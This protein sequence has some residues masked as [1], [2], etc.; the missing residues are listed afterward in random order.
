[1]KYPDNNDESAFSK[2]TDLS[3]KGLGRAKNTILQSSQTVKARLDLTSLKREEYRLMKALGNEVFTALK[4][5]KLETDLFDSAVSKIEEIQA[6][7]HEKEEESLNIGV[8]TL[9]K[10]PSSMKSTSEEISKDKE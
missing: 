2:F 9:K 1:M 4:S 7:I 3:R 5:K 10:S 8:S 6:R